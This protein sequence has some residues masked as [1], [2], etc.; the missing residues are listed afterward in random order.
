[1]KNRILILPLIIVAGITLTA[2]SN[3]FAAGD[4]GQSQTSEVKHA[5]APAVSA[6][7]W[8]VHDLQLAEQANLKNGLNYMLNWG[9]GT[10]TSNVQKQMNQLWFGVSTNIKQNPLFGYSWSMMYQMVK[11]QPQALMSVSVLEKVVQGGSTAGVLVS[12]KS[13]SLPN[14]ASIAFAN[15]QVITAANKSGEL[16]YSVYPV[17]GVSVPSTNVSASSSAKLS[18]YGTHDFGLTERTY[19]ST[20]AAFN[21]LNH[22]QDTS[23]GQF[24]PTGS[25]VSLGSGIK[26]RHSNK[27]GLNS[28]SWKEGRWSVVTQFWANTPD[29]LGVSRNMVSYMHSHMLPAPYSKGFI[30]AVQPRTSKRSNHLVTIIAWQVGSHL[31]ELKRTGNPVTALETVL[32]MK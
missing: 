6:P 14:Y 17:K 24:I 3:S 10:V 1:M 2:C 21:A 12:A 8:F 4:A 5:A 7:A 19:P 30:T 28:Y 25:D 11:S 9:E 20:A 31:Y 32:T 13:M 29:A 27:G 23:I 15:G 16:F 26:A 22:L 18:E